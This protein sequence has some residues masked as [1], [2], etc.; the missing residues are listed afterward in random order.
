MVGL[1]CDE[2]F[3]GKEWLENFRMSKDT[4]KYTYVCNQLREHLKKKDYFMRQSISAEKDV[5]VTIWCL[6]TNVEYQLIG[7][8]F[9]YQDLLYVTCTVH[10]ARSLRT[11]TFSVVELSM[12]KYIKWPTREH[13]TNVIHVLKQKWGFTQCAGAVDRSHIPI[14]AS[15][16]FHNNYFDRKGWH[17]VMLRGVADAQYCFKDINV[18]WPNSVHDARVVSQSDVHKQGQNGTLCC[19][20]C[21]ILAWT[22]TN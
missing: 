14:L 4:Y 11:N 2:N 9:E 8:L 21:C 3:Q 18:G 22:N 5:S 20:T 12:P 15:K 19:A 13:L 7:H 16:D 1:D 17:S 10:R 6:A